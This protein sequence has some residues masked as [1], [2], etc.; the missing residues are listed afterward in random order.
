VG[1]LHELRGDTAEAVRIYN[2]LLKL[3]TR[4]ENT[5]A[6]EA[7]VVRTRLTLLTRPS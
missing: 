2:D 7:S 6:R 1:E 5:V 3:W 4:A